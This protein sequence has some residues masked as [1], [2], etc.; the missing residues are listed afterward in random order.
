[1][2]RTK[3]PIE[4]FEMQRTTSPVLKKM[5]RT[6]VIPQ[7]RN[8]PHGLFENTMYERAY[9]L[10][11]LGLTL[12]ELAI[13]FGIK[14]PTMEAWLKKDAKF[15]RAVDMGRQEADA[16][17]AY[18]LYKR[19]V[20]YEED[21]IHFG[22]YRGEVIMTPFKRRIIPD[23]TAQQIWLKNR[24]RHLW[25][26]RSKIEVEGTINHKVASVNIHVLDEQEKAVFQ[27]MIGIEE[28]IKFNLDKEANNG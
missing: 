19:A 11:L 9:R 7:H 8:S 24:Q 10:M 18:S 23:V 21:D 1:M 22:I 12:K 2:K 16:N 17:V 20:G 13:A 3:Q 5:K 28:P 26:D 14:D 6:K 4:K 25:M 15:K 27:K